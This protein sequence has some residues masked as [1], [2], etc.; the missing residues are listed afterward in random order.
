MAAKRDPFKD[1]AD[2]LG[3]ISFDRSMRLEALSEALKRV[4][5]RQARLHAS[6]AELQRA[7]HGSMGREESKRP[8]W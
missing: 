8:G 7:T 1:L 6:S 4:E 3:D 5:A 2:L